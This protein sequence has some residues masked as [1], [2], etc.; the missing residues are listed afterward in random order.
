MSSTSE[1][2]S[3]TSSNPS[4]IP[5][6][7]EQAFPDGSKRSIQVNFCKNPHCRNFG[8]PASLE[9]YARRSK[10]SPGAPGTE[11]TLGAAGAGFPVLI[12][13]LCGESLPMKSNLG[14]GEE[15]YRLADYLTPAELPAC[16]SAACE[17]RLVPVNGNKKAYYAFGKTSQG[18]KRYKCRSCGK[19]F[20][21]GQRATL[22]QRLPQ[23]NLQLFRLL[24]NKMPMTRICEVAG[25]SIQTL[26]DKID[27]I[28]RQCVAFVAEH[29]RKLL[30]GLAI[31]RLYVAVDRQDYVINWT[32]RK[33]KRNITLRALGSADLTSGYVFGMHL[34]FDSGLDSLAIEVDAREA[35]DYAAQYPFRRYARLWLEGDYAKAVKETATRLSKKLKSGATLG[36]D[37]AAAY[38]EAEARADV[39]APELITSTSRFPAKGMQVRNEYTLY[40]HFYWLHQMFKGVEK[41]RF[42]LDQESGIRAACLS[43]FEAE[44]KA[45]K[46]EAFYV[47]LAKEMTVDE[48][49]KIVAA[50]R[51]A[52]DE[53]LAANPGATRAEVEVL[54]MKAEIERASAIGKW[55]DRWATH[56]FPNSSEPNKAMCWLTSRS[57]DEKDEAADNEKTHAEFGDHMARLHLKAS[58]HAIDRFFMQIRRR[59]SLL[60]RP[61]STSSKAGRTWYGYSAYKP[62][63]I[64]KLLDI[65]RVFY[66]YCLSDKKGETPAMRMG[67]ADR[68]MEPQDIL[69]FLP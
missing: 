59:L 43:A 36:D 63:N 14:I 45:K 15:I 42:Y 56:P 55:S 25:I 69:Q 9:K 16:P 8:V 54:M 6:A 53:A 57:W 66:N 1:A 61:I 21:V 46:C 13:K 28:H 62:E 44:V 64:V 34:N 27:F 52:F 47:R 60:E 24:M 38:S 7:V 68:P 67:L 26:Y 4:K 35:G 5:L 20:S 19:T 37:I 51:A 58:L 3:K 33:D 30:E 29:E 23:K 50:S 39:E 17:N 11:Y 22:R 41:V 12:C 10:S 31:S 40:A 18:S 49:R 32:Q 65:F 48:K 2:S